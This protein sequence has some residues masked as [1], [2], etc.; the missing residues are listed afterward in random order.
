M[1]ESNT[2]ICSLN[3]NFKFCISEIIIKKLTNQNEEKDID[4]IVDELAKQTKCTLADND[5]K[6]GLCILKTLANEA[7]NK[8]IAKV[9]SGAILTEFKPITKDFDHN[10]WLNNTEI[11]HIQHQLA[12]LFKGYYYSYIH[13][14]DLVMIDPKHSDKLDYEVYPF[15]D[16]NF[17]NE[18]KKENHVLTHNGD[19]KYYGV[20]MNTDHSSGGGIHWFSIFIDFT[21]SPHTIEYF[22]SSGYDIKNKEF[23]KFLLNLKHDI[24]YNKQLNEK[25]NIGPC[26]FIKVTSIQHQ[27]S[28]TANC[29]SYALYYI[30]ERL[31]GT[32]YSYF[33]NNKITDEKARSF[34]EILYRLD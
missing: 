7:E 24:N 6:K 19:L 30:Y 16:I 20:V 28:T 12:H 21:A 11:D 9:A 26:E 1:S 2:N 25:I 22:N 17:I 8:E 4:D 23:K 13:M 33:A 34:R 15:K 32:P 29:G 5:P 3:N 14:I 27:L 31:N 18:L 10:N